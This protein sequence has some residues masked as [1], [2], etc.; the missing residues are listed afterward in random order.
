MPNLVKMKPILMFLII[1]TFFSCSKEN[2][3]S[4]KPL[5]V[6]YVD[7]IPY[8]MSQNKIDSVFEIISYGEAGHL[9]I[10]D[11]LNSY[12]LNEDNAVIQKLKSFMC[13]SYVY[14]FDSLGLLQQK[15]VSTDYVEYFSFDRLRDEDVI[16]E[17]ESSNMGIEIEYKYQIE[18][19]KIVSRVGKIK[20]DYEFSDSTHY[21]YSNYDKIKTK[22]RIRLNDSNGEFTDDNI[23]TSYDWNQ[24]VLK[25]VDIKQFLIND[26]IEPYFTTIISF[27]SNGFPIEKVLFKK[28]EIVC[29]TRLIR[30]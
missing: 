6:E 12:S 29:R 10:G 8:L 28:Q 18:N 11:T 5:L 26:E 25:R 13:C 15:R 7:D 9:S 1:M 21:E 23:V 17:S 3:T 16:Y 30:N 20:G 27:D 2:K 4:L 14:K 22:I 24:N 19:K